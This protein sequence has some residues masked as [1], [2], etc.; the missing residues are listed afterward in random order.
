MAVEA[1]RLFISV[2]GSSECSPE[3][4]AAAEAVGRE[5][6]RRDA[7]LVCGGGPGIMEAACRGAKLVGGLTVGILPEADGSAANLYVDIPIVTGLG[8]ARNSVVILTGHAA[9]AVGGAYGTLSEIAYARM[10]R[11]AVIGLGTWELH[12]SRLRDRPVEVASGPIDA[13]EKAL[14]AARAFRERAVR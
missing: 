7:V 10:Y 6:A 11:R 2:I 12:A 4:A 5:L 14:A 9:I 1:R 13:V 3:E 8:W